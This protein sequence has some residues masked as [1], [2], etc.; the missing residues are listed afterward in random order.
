MPLADPERRKA[1]HRDYY[2]RNTD[3][4]KAQVHRRYWERREDILAQ[5]VVYNHEKKE[6]IR[7][8]RQRKRRALART[9]LA[10]YSGGTCECVCCGE[11]EESFLTVDHIDNDGAKHRKELRRDFYTW[12]VAQGFPEGYQTLCR[13]CNWGKHR[14]GGVCPHMQPRSE[15]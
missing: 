5:K 10:Y 9:V 7:E 3:L 14:N 1:Y 2:R 13:N 12:L 4:M 15:R 6:T 11:S 8:K